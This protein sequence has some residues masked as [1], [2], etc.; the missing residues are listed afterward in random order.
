MKNVLNILAIILFIG[1]LA[2]AESPAKGKDAKIK[3]EVIEHKD[4]VVAV[5]YATS[6]KGT[7]VIRIKDLS[8]GEIVH[9]EWE[10][11]QMLA[12]KRYD[13]SHL[14]AG[15]YLVEVSFGKDVFK[16]KIQL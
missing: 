2:L 12:V 9:S 7:V 1:N 6:N 13:L 11:N 10:S 5:H 16:K 4:D 3:V 15:K 8:N 14:P